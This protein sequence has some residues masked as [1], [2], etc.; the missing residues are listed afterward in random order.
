[1]A[2]SIP[3]T[4]KVLTLAQPRQHAADDWRWPYVLCAVIQ[5]LQR[6]HS[7]VRLCSILVNAWLV[8]RM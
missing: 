8:G 3:H 4:F 1:M 5:A 6:A 2:G 7:L